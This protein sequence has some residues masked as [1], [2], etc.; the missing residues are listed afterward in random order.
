MFEPCFNSSSAR[1]VAIDGLPTVDSL[2]TN[3]RPLRKALLE[4]HPPRQTIAKIPITIDN[5]DKNSPSPNLGRLIDAGIRSINGNKKPD[6]AGTSIGSPFGRFSCLSTDKSK[7][8][9][10]AHTP[11]A[12]DKT[13]PVTSQK[14][15]MPR[16][17][18]LLQSFT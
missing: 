17:R 13:A 9:T 6:T 1:W 8:N 11:P 4:C 16:P 14:I 12:N 2:V 5:S 3:S 18:I 7:A 10:S 15:V